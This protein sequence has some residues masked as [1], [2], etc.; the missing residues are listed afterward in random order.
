MTQMKGEKTKTGKD[1]VF[2]G[3]DVTIRVP[4]IWI[5]F[6]RE[7]YEWINEGE[8]GAK[9]FV[10]YVLATS[11]KNEIRE[12]LVELRNKYPKVYAQ[13]RKKHPKLAHSVGGKLK[14]LRNGYAKF[15]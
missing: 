14:L 1:E 5:D 3:I 11:L 8:A 2:E 6:L 12:I 9:E 13:F 7:Y 10:Q 4:K 15:G